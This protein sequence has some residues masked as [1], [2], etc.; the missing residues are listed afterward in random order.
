MRL[1]AVIKFLLACLVVGIILAALGA[2]PSTMGVWLADTASSIGRG[3]A[4]FV[5]WGGGY[6]VMGAMVLVPILVIRW[7]LRKG[8]KG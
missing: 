1:G 5:R 2:T 4:N 6:M 8:K 3:L 7:L